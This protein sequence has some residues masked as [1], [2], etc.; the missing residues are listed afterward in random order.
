MSYDFTYKRN[1]ENK[2]N[3]KNGIKSIDTDKSLIVARWEEGW[4]WVKRDRD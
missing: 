1:Q 3:M 2:I 4:E